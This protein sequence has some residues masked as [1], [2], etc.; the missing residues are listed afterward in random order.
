MGPRLT[1]VFLTF[2]VPAQGGG[3]ARDTR[4]PPRVQRMLC[5]TNTSVQTVFFWDL[6]NWVPGLATRLIRY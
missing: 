5:P 4:P 6:I 3:G 2:S 1:V